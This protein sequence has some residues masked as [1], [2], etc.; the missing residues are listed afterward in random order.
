MA[1]GLIW[2]WQWDDVIYWLVSEMIWYESQNRWPDWKICKIFNI[3]MK[4]VPKKVSSYTSNWFD[5]DYI[6]T[7][8]FFFSFLFLF[9]Y[10]VKSINRFDKREWTEW[11]YLHQPYVNGEPQNVP[12]FYD[13]SNFYVDAFRTSLLFTIPSFTHIRNLEIETDLLKILYK[14]Y[15]RDTGY[16]YR[17]AIYIYNHGNRREWKPLRSTATWTVHMN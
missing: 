1:R 4:F 5:S 11:K 9:Q 17:S 7:V 12:D 6:N 14:Y 3:Q 15:T 2:K 8:S 13:K 10:C 16:K